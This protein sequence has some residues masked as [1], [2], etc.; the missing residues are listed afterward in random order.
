V[1]PGTPVSVVLQLDDAAP[2][3]VE[4]PV[5]KAAPALFANVVRTGNIPT[6][7]GTGE[8]SVNPRLVWGDLN[9]SARDSP[10]TEPATV[11]VTASPPKSS[12]REPLPGDG[13]A[14]S[15]STSTSPPAAP[16]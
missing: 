9:I 7:Y 13:P 15:N 3:L 4:V 10:P 16:P 6:L 11:T 14:S 8:G 12:T 2:S 1:P 5:A